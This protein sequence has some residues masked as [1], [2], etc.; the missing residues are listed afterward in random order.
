MKSNDYQAKTIEETVADIRQAA[1]SG[2]PASLAK[3]ISANLEQRALQ[4]AERYEQRFADIRE[5]T[6]T[7]ILMSRG[8]RQL[9]SGERDYYQKVL[10]AMRSA[11]PRQALQNIDLTLPVTTINAVFDELESEHPL[12]SRLNIRTVRG[13]TKLLVDTSEYQRAQWGELCDDIVKEISAGFS[14]AESGLYK[15]SA[16]MFACK[17][18]LE[19]GPEWLDQYVRE[20]LYETLANGLEYAFIDG[21]G[22]TMPI[23]MTR[24]VGA[25]VTV[26]D[27]VYPRKSQIAVTDLTPAT[28]GNLI[29]LMARGTTGRSRRVRDLILIVNP[30]DYFQKVMPAT[31]LQAPDGTYRNDVLPYPIDILQSE[32]L[33]RGQA[34]L[35]IASRY[36]AVA[37]ISPDGRIEYSDEYRFG[38][39]KRTYI[40][41]T[42]ANGLPM[43]N[44]AFLFLD[45]SGL[46]PARWKV[47]AV[48][49]NTPSSDAALSALSLGAATLSPAFAAETTSYTAATSNAS[50]TVNAVPADAG[51]NISVKLNGAD[52]ANGSA[53]AWTAGENT[54]A[55]TVTAADGVT[56]KTYTVTV[57][58]S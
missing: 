6:D 37:G 52:A 56:T 22:K 44:N 8:V 5:Q 35:G 20:I 3:A 26:T 51:A 49:P 32:A 19:L 48:S 17:P 9:T 47:Q 15:L 23:G 11:D 13:N 45:I 34:V 33:D 16:L 41:K 57:A 29:S 24:Q 53:L 27:G 58:K 2:D 42:Y 10:D 40:I 4:I 28:V 14:V 12:L 21:T 38:E 25:G 50:N 43:D 39:D 1:E 55:V 31:T 18:G 36:F 46:T 54:V 30:E 7:Q